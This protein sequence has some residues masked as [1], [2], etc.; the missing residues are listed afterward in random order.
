MILYYKKFLIKLL[1]FY[2]IIEKSNKTYYIC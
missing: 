1:K 2:K